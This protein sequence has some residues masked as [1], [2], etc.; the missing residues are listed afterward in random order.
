MILDAS[1]RLFSVRYVSQFALGALKQICGL[2]QTPTEGILCAHYADQ[3]RDQ[4]KKC[5]RPVDAS[6]GLGPI[7]F[8]SGGA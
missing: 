4:L 6:M 8:R 7:P 1:T 5:W 2:L 3:S